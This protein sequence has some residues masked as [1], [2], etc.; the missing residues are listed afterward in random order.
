MNRVDIS[1]LIISKLKNL[2]LE[3]LENEYARSG[4]INHIVIDGLLPREIAL[5]L[6]DIFPPESE[7]N[8]FNGVQEKNM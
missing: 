5:K 8:L 4:P 7:L 2:N 3:F 6:N 1:K